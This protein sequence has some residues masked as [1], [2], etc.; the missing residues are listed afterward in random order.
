MPIEALNLLLN[1]KIPNILVLDF[2]YIF[3]LELFCFGI[4]LRTKNCHG[5]LA[6]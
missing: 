1:N 6:L 5:H 2:F 4:L 3:I